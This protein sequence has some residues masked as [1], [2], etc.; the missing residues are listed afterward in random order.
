MNSFSL[1]GKYFDI[2]NGIHIYYTKIRQIYND[3]T[4]LHIYTIDPGRTNM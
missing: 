2:D 4:T 1:T 3:L